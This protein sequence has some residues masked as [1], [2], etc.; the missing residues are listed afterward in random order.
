MYNFEFSAHQLPF[1]MEGKKKSF[2]SN[3]LDTLCVRDTGLR[4]AYVGMQVFEKVL[5]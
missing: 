1:L 2:S 4:W 3:N 5:N